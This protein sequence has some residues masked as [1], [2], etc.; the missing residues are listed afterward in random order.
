MSNHQANDSQRLSLE[1]A[2]QRSADDYTAMDT[3][4][5]CQQL[6]LFRLAGQ[7]FA[8]P[9]SSVTEILSSDQPIYFVPGLPSSTQGVIHLRGRIESVIDFAPLLGLPPS[10]P[11][12]MILLVS[13]GGIRSGVRIAYLDD[14]CDVPLSSLK[15]TPA[16]LS[17]EWRPYVSALWQPDERTAT[18]LLDADALFNAYQQGLG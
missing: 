6:V 1:Q 11:H 17:N 15:P 14:V 5:P 18:A 2:L 13:A 7:P 10:E 3:E 4:E 8:L 9:G 16:T 12:G